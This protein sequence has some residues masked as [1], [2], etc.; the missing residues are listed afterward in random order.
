MVDELES[1]LDIVIANNKALLK[2][3]Q[4]LQAQLLV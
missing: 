2:Q 3:L 4:E 1:E